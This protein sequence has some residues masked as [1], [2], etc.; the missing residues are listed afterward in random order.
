MIA[1]LYL[2][3]TTQTSVNVGSNKAHEY[4]TELGWAVKGEV[5]WHVGVPVAGADV[6]GSVEQN[7]KYVMK[8]TDTTLNSKEDTQSHTVCLILMLQARVVKGSKDIALT[9]I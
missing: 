8:W 5:K 1:D 9:D 2:E 6:G 7:G 4:G 3:M